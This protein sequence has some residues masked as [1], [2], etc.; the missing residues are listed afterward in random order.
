LRTEYTNAATSSL[1]PD[2]APYPIQRNLTQKM[3]EEG[4]AS[5]DLTK[6]QAWAGQS[7]G[8]ALAIPAKEIIANLWN[9]TQVILNN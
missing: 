8:L 7:I 1:A 9:G 6:I 2:A 3:R 5:N 4:V